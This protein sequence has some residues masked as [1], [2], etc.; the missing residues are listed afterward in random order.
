MSDQR[1]VFSPGLIGC[2]VLGFL[3][4]LGMMAWLMRPQMAKPSP[5]P[6][7]EEIEEMRA[8]L[9]LQIDPA[10][11]VRLQ[12][13]VDYAQGTNAAWYPKAEAPLLAELVKEGRLPPLPERIGPEPIVYRGPDGIGRYGGTWVTGG[14]SPGNRQSA[15]TLVR[16]SPEGYPIV[17]HFAKSWETSADC[18]TYTFHLRKG[19]RWSDGHP[20]TADDILYWWEHEATDK[21]IS[22]TIP[23]LM[24]IRG[25]HGTVEKVDD[26]T[27]RFV[28]PE[29]HGLFVP[30]L[31]MFHG[32]QVVGSP[33]HYL[34]RYH[35][36]P[37]IGDPELIAKEMALRRLPAARDLYLQVKLDTNTEH[38]RLWPWL[39][40][41]FTADAPYSYVRNPYYCMVDPEGNQLPYVDQV[42]SIAISR[43]MMPS[44]LAGGRFTMGS[45]KSVD[46][47]L[48]LSLRKQGDYRVLRWFR[49]DRCDA[50]IHVNLNRR[51][52][53]GDKHTEWKHRLLNMTQ[54]RQALS[55]AIDRNAIIR[56]IYFGETFPAQCAPGPNSFFHHEASYT[57]FTQFDPALANRWLDEIGLDRRDVNGFRVA[58]DGTHLTFFLH[59]WSGLQPGTAQFIVDDWARVGI[60]AIPKLQ[61]S[62]LFYTSK[63]GLQHDL[64]M[65]TGE[66]ELIPI[67]S[68]RVFLPDQLEANFAIGYANWYSRGGL[69]DSPASK[70]PGCIPVPREHPLYESLLA[71]E[72]VKSTADTTEQKKHFNTV[73][74]IAASNT[75]TIGICTSPKYV[76]NVQN[77]FSNV[78][79]SA[80]STFTF[81]SPGNTGQ[82]TYYFANAQ[83]TPER[84][85]AIKNEIVTIVPEPRTVGAQAKARQKGG[86]T[87]LGR[88]IQWSLIGV[89]V[90]LVLM[91]AVRHPYIGRRLLIMIPTL[92]FISVVVFTIIQ[93]PPGDYLTS[94]VVELQMK[95]DAVDEQELA[96]IKAMY[97]LDDPVL[98]RYC[99]WMGFAWFFS[100]QAKDEGLLQGNLG[101]SMATNREVSQ[102]VGD[103]IT[104]TI[105][106]SLGSI[107]FTWA[108]ALPVGIYSAVR[109]YSIADYILTFVG[110]IGMCIPSF[111]LAVVLMYW[112]QKY[113][114]MQIF[115][116]LSPKFA[117]QPY[118]DLA[119]FMDLLKHLWIPVIILGIGGTGGM[120]RVM[121]ANLLDELKKPYVVTARAKGVRPAKL[122]FKYPVR[123]ALNPFI[124]GIGGLFPALISGGTLISV[125][126]S[127]PTVGPMML[128]ALMNEDT[129]LAGSM[130]MVLSV[131]GVLGVLVSDL[132]L[133]WIDPRIR[134]EGGSR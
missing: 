95:G 79:S 44:A 113:L 86:P 104:L 131:L 1:R 50:M 98:I 9:A 33:A 112:C 100:F 73:L 80:A 35:P 27:V 81:L 128:D 13:D 34:R 83:R 49:A 93:L 8:A 7:A 132:L 53:P 126:L 123:I 120:I 87:R 61:A 82:E 108:L 57:N 42:Y 64:T 51:V 72:R 66:N 19:M 47:T 31:A 20:F 89:A 105:L 54:F 46:Y 121:R 84:A 103:R 101:R 28:F 125:V 78:A 115:G 133:L 37:A 75:W 99:R 77:G 114:G 4:F 62:A 127:L 56:S 130:L 22:G 39:Y 90:A 43:D 109:Q 14:A 96:N 124:S 36:D 102:I 94:R 69:F 40:N 106:L 119:K 25:K 116:L 122:L 60:H 6:P 91:S 110:F 59:Y 26:L 29:S 117:M 17:P 134:F 21:R 76:V 68:P 41:T 107:L 10:N 11:P 88:T 63:A 65:W 3:A 15:P 24:T 111:L 52:E 74:D 71:Y 55:V 23:P 97:H 16:W 18:K 45:S 12:V 67:L 129:L 32:I 58:P 2:T 30:M 5:P 70:G 92:L 118:W 48:I 38:P 85:A